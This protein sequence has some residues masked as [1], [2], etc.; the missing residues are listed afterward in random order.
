MISLFWVT[1]YGLL[2][3]AFVFPVYFPCLFSAFV[4]CVYFLCLFSAFIFH[5][6]FQRLFSAFV[7][8]AIFSCSVC[9]KKERVLGFLSVNHGVL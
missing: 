4:F 2:F 6:C 5:V 9:I 7:L 1:F 3:S 8:R